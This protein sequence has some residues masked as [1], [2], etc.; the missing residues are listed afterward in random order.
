[1]KPIILTLVLI[2]L[3][4]CNSKKSELKNDANPNNNTQQNNTEKQNIIKKYIA[5]IIDTLP[6]NINYFTQGLVFH[7]GILYEGT[8]IE[9]E[10][11]LVRYKKNKHSADKIV[12]LDDSVFGEG[13]TVF[14][15]KI[16]QL[17]WLN[18]TCFVYDLKTLNKEKELKYA[19]EGWGLTHNDSLLIMSDGSATIRF[20][21]PDNF[22]VV[23][24]MMIKMNGKAVGLINELELVDS[25]LY[26]NIYMQDLIIIADINT[27]NVVG[28][29]DISNLRR[30]LYNNPTQEVSNGIAY[31]KSEDVFYLTGKNWNKVFIVRFKERE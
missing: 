12:R 10:S 2:S 4:A 16:Y 25:L 22:R 20:I 9:G 27:G 3:F 29:I 1:M 30:Q 11:I 17:S 18:Q 5:E 26:A 14:N 28:L 15:D 13:I 24:N 23:R 21:E 7:N 19:G 31:N 8:G 6:H